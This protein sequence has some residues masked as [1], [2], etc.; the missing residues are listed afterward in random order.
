MVDQAEAARERASRLAQGIRGQAEEA[1]RREG[2]EGT[3]GERGFGMLAL[4][5]E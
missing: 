3:G 5:V 1:R 2:T 4:L